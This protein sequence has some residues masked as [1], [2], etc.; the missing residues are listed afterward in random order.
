MDNRRN[1][2]FVAVFLRN[3]FQAIYFL[4]FLNGTIIDEAQVV[5]VLKNHH[6]NAQ[7]SRGA[8][9]WVHCTDWRKSKRRPLISL[10]VI[11]LKRSGVGHFSAYL[12]WPSASDLFDLLQTERTSMLRGAQ[13]CCLHRASL[14]EL[15]IATSVWAFAFGNRLISQ[16]ISEACKK[17]FP[18]EISIKYKV[19]F[20]VSML[21]NP[22]EKLHTALRIFPLASTYWLQYWNQCFSQYMLA[23]VFFAILG[24]NFLT[25]QRNAIEMNHCCMQSKLKFFV[26]NPDGFS[27]DYIWGQ[28]RL[29]NK[30]AVSP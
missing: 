2:I 21:R 14:F 13:L 28:S 1:I 3:K 12:T 23:T 17:K 5:K 30:I 15:L 11:C 29:H 26:C 24:T 6:G 4:F 22:R 27:R 10:S 16:R 20:S 18:L 8:Q 7:R 25:N 19:Q 9:Q